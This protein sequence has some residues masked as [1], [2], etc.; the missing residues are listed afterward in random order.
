MWGVERTLTWLAKYRKLTIRSDRR[1][2]IREAFV[3]LGWHLIWSQLP[4]VRVVEG[5]LGAG[6][7]TA[8]RAYSGSLGQHLESQRRASTSLHSR[9]SSSFGAEWT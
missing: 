8:S 2:G 3:H 5:S 6:D 9:T 7:L 1:Y 4:G